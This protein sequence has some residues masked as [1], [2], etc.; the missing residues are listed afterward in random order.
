MTPVTRTC[1]YE[2]VSIGVL[3]SCVS[4]DRVLFGAFVVQRSAQF[5]RQQQNNTG[6]G[7]SIVV[8]IV[9]ASGSNRTIS[10]AILGG[11]GGA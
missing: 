8:T 4:C 11:K 5:I 9:L 2:I 1:V 10:G 6:M 3:L 7:A